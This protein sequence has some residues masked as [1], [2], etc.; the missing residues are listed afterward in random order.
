MALS[1]VSYTAD[2]ITD[3]FVVPFDYILAEH[4]IVT[5]DGVVTSAYTYTETALI[6]MNTVPLDGV[7]IYISRDSELEN[8][9]T[10][11]L[12]GGELT[13]SDLNTDS[14]QAIYLIQEASDAFNKLE[15]DTYIK[16]EVDAAIAL[17]TKIAYE[18]ISKNL[19]SWDAILSYTLGNLIAITYSDGIFTIIKTFNYTVG[20][21]TSIVLSGDTPLQIDLTKTFTY[22]SGD[23]IG[24]AYT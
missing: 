13:E 21:L 12:D 2:G 17:K 8:R 15:G 19:D 16:T 18:T 23:I 3:E 6:K 22:S 11:Y 14:K 1:N 24:W 9:L 5:V 10:A 4:V 7:V 20:D